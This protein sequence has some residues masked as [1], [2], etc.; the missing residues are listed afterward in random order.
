MAGGE[1]EARKELIFLG[2]G[3]YFAAFSYRD[4][5]FVWKLPLDHLRSL[6]FESRIG[7]YSQFS[8]ESRFRFSLRKV[9]KLSITNLEHKVSRAI[10]SLSAIP[11]YERYFAFSQKSNEMSLKLN[12]GRRGVVE[13]RGF[14]V[15]QEKL[16]PVSKKGINLDDGYASKIFQINKFF[17]SHG[18]GFFRYAELLGFENHAWTE[19]QQLKGFDLTGVTTNREKLMSRVG[20]SNPKFC[21][22]LDGL[23]NKLRD[24]NSSDSIESFKRLCLKNYS[25][26]IIA[27][28]WGQGQK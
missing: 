2:A 14:C 15:I 23:C 21:K 7:S 17:W 5:P 1:P 22:Y 18:I 26:E 10:D 28:Y 27:R 8:T 9:G 19:D 6:G 3:V 20:E 13:T 12:L 25:P 4:S 24:G 11:N 16:T